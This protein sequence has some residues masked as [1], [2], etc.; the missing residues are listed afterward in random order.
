MWK[1]WALSIDIFMHFLYILYYTS[2]SDILNSLGR[3]TWL[4]IELGSIGDLA[5][6]VIDTDYFP[7]L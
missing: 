5:K 4:N 6:G 1:R 2:L 7:S 3:M